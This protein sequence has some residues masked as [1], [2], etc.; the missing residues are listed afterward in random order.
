M[1]R[2]D[3]PRQRASIGNVKAGIASAA[4]GAALAGWAVLSAAPAQQAA[5]PQ[6]PAAGLP[7][8]GADAAAQAAPFGAPQAGA[9]PPWQGERNHH[10]EW[11]EHDEGRP[12]FGARPEGGERL[13]PFAREPRAQTAP[14]TTQ[15]QAQVGPGTSQQPSWPRAPITSTRSS[16]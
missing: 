14:D 2:T 11:G 4:V 10:G 9:L 3:S 16:R 1:T 12:L 5:T 7:S 6:Q 15:P 8:S 13:D